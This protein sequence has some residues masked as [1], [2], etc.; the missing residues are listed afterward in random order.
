MFS[1]PFSS[2]GR[3][4]RSEFGISCIISGFQNVI[5]NV[6]AMDE[7]TVIIALVIY[8]SLINSL[9]ILCLLCVYSILFFVWSNMKANDLKPHLVEE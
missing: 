5:S 8:I 6:L 4:R 3:I 1:N 9:F 7:S 2:E